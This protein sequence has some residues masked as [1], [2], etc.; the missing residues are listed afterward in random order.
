MFNITVCSQDLSDIKTLSNYLFK[1]SLYNNFKYKLNTSPSVCDILTNFRDKVDIIFIFLKDINKELLININNMLKNKFSNIRI[2]YVPEI[3]DFMINGF[4]LKDYNYIINPITFDSFEDELI[5]LIC[6][7]K[8]KS[9]LD[10]LYEDIAKFDLMNEIPHKDI[11]YIHTCNS[12]C[13]LHTKN[14][15]IKLSYTLD[16]LIHSLDST[17]MYRCNNEYIVNLK[18]INKLGR[19]F[20]ISNSKYIAV[21]EDRFELLKNKLIAIFNLI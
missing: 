3:I 13:I 15:S 21:D 18:K 2:I 8:V 6:G 12:G 17:F 20:V 9:N 7:L 10:I 16:T 1:L 4:C 19:H 5:S 11:F 14:S